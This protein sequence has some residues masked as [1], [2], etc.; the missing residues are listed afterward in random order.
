MEL[1]V[2]LAAVAVLQA[3]FAAKEDY[4]DPSLCDDGLTHIA[5]DQDQVFKKHFKKLKNINLLL[6]VFEKL[7]WQS[8]SYKF[9]GTQQKTHSRS[10]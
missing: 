2:L 4:C 1:K 7:W 6:G 5:C 10:A 3:V 8:R 9:V